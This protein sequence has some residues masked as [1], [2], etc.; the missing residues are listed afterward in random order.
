[1]V[2]HIHRRSIPGRQMLETVNGQGHARGEGQEAHRATDYF[3]ALGRRMGEYMD[4]R[5]EV[6]RL[7]EVE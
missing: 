4:G 5:A 2:G 6:I 3:K 7:R 1:M